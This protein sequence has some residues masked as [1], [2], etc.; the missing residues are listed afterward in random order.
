MEAFIIISLFVLFLYVF[1]IRRWLSRWEGTPEFVPVSNTDTAISVV[2][3]FRNEIKNLPPLL[4]SLEKQIY[5]AALFE[6][7][8]VDDNS[9]DGSDEIVKGFCREH[10]NFK[11]LLNSLQPGKKSSLSV[12]IHSAVNEL[13]VTTDADA[14][15]PQE[16]LMT[17]SN[18]YCSSYPD[19]IIGLTD[20]R[21]SSGFTA[22]FFEAEFLSL[23]AS[24]A[25]AVASEKP[26]FCNGANLAFTK[27]FYS[28]NSQFVRNSVASGDDTFLLHSAKKSGSRICLLKSAKSVV[29][30]KQPPGVDEFFHQHKRWVSKSRYYNDK[31]IIIIALLVLA[32][33]IITGASLLMLVI[34]RQWIFLVL[35]AIKM[36]VDYQLVSGFYSY[37]RRRLTITDFILFSLIYPYYVVITASSGILTGYSWKGRFYKS[38]H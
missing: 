38:G 11:Y 16:W 8:L 29:R 37:Y 4:A 27:S 24:G 30:V 13:I 21:S 6:V 2:I 7:I 3:A 20:I 10:S 26:I 22:R 9:D 33:N 5:P 28:K 17:I 34:W 12:G 32:M 19:F 14:I 25:C 36:V 31:D 1:Q 18:F 15:V 23:I 35:A